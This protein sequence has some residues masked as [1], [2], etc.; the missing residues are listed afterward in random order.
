MIL[1]QSDPEQERLGIP[2]T[3]RNDFSLAVLQSTRDLSNFGTHKETINQSIQPMNPDLLSSKQTQPRR[4]RR[5]KA[6][7]ACTTC[8]RRKLK[9][10]GARPACSRCQR[11]SEALETCTYTSNPVPQSH[12]DV[13]P[14]RPLHPPASDPPLASHRTTIPTPP[15]EADVLSNTDPSEFAPKTRS[16]I[17]TRF[18]L[19]APLK[20]CGCPIPLINAPI[21]G[22]LSLPEYTPA[23][24]SSSHTDRVL[25]PRKHADHLVS[26][27]WQAIEPHEPLLDYNRFAHAYQ[28]LFTGS[29]LACNETKNMLLDQRNEAIRA[30]FLLHCIEAVKS[31]L[32]LLES[33]QRP[34]PNTAPSMDMEE[35]A[36]PVPWW[37]R[38]FYLYIALQHLI[39]AILRPDI[40]GDTAPDLWEKGI[41]LLTVHT[42]LSVSVQKYLESFAGMWRKVLDIRDFGQ[43]QEQM[44]IQGPSAGGLVGGEFSADSEF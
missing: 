33:R 22:D 42:H 37:H 27:Y 36:I 9:C 24:G 13:Q 25:P 21:F 2:H 23:N 18:G 8:R 30:F 11:K 35:Q 31:I 20:K 38:I 16:T 3:A 14:P 43:M 41:A 26:L 39:A 15:V 32:T 5:Y 7:I 29:D 6:A 10:N 17:Y 1:C 40:F 44:Q 34:D 19:P 4:Q 12:R 28:A